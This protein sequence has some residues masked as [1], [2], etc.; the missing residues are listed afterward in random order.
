[1]RKKLGSVSKDIGH[2]GNK[3]GDEGSRSVKNFVVDTTITEEEQKR[4]MNQD[5]CR[6]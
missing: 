2:T 5:K 1:M 6:R 3:F 4:Q